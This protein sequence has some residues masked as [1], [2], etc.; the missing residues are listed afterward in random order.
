MNT[1]E[2]SAFVKTVEMN[3]FSLAANSLY[4]TQS[5]LSQ[6]IQRL[7]RGLGFAL[8]EHSQRKAVLTPAGERFYVRAKQMLA[9]YKD[10]QE[11]GLYLSRLAERKMQR[12]QIGCLNDQFIRYWLDLLGLTAE[13][14]QD[15]AP[16]PVRYESRTALLTSIVNKETDLSLQMEN[17]AIQASHL[18]FIPLTTVREVCQLMHNNTPGLLDKTVLSVQDLLPYTLA[19]H[20]PPGTTLFEDELRGYIKLHSPRTKILEP[21]DFFEADYES[22]K[23][24]LV[25]AP[26][27]FRPLGSGCLPLDFGR[28]IRLGFVV[29]PNCDG[30]VLNYIEYIQTHMPPDGDLWGFEKLQIQ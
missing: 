29:S 3:S 19:F 9:L 13:V 12:L 14:S 20:N 7:E 4:L 18:V 6:Q 30:R 10:A 11:E 21:K 8:F 22:E 25:P 16:R 15:Y 2:L 1:A 17:A 5:A 24:F 28:N 23:I 27:F 26:Q